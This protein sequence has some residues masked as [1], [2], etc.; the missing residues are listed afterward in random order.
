MMTGYSPEE[1]NDDWEFKIV[2]SGTNA[3]RNPDTFAQLVDEE[4]EAGWTLLEKLDNGR[5]RFKRPKN[6]HRND[7]YL[8]DHIDPYRT[9][10]GRT[11]QDTPTTITMV[12]TGVLLVL[13]LLAAMLFMGRQSSNIIIALVV[14][15]ILVFGMLGIFVFRNRR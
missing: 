15:A 8:P 3:F 1:L 2:R 5:V 10:F 7:A 4:A 11:I 6:A 9:Q 14:G 12:I 13:G